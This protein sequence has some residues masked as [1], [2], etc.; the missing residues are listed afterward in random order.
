MTAIEAQNDVVKKTIWSSNTI[1]TAVILGSILIA[2]VSG[3]NQI[4]ISKQ[5]IVELKRER[6]VDSSKIS[7]MAGDIKAIRA[8]MERN[9]RRP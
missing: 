4:A 9:D 8:V 1:Q 3:W 6:D 7:E 2:G 5:D